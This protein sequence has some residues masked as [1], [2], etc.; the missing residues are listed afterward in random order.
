MAW[1]K[2]ADVVGRMPLEVASLAAA[3]HRVAMSQLQGACAFARSIHSVI[4][5]IEIALEECA[6]PRALARTSAMDYH[7]LKGESGYWSSVAPAP[8]GCVCTI[9]DA[10]IRRCCH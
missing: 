7:S 3:P 6:A 1:A 2:R 5:K 9:L 4:S 10:A 8:G